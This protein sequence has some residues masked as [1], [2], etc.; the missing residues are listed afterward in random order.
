MSATCSPRVSELPYIQPLGSSGSRSYSGHSSTRAETGTSPTSTPSSRTRRCPVS[1][2][3]PIAAA[4]VCQRSQVATTS[5]SRDGSTTASIR[6]CDSETI[7]SKGSRSGS[8]S[9]TL[10]T[11]M[12]S[13]DA[14][15]RRHLAGRGGQP[16]RAEVLERDEQSALEQLQAALEQ[17]RF[18]EGVADLDAGALAVVPGLE[19]RRGEHRGAADPVASGGRAHDHQQVPGAGGGGADHRVGPGEPD[20]HRVHQAVVLVRTA[21][22]RPRR[23]P[24]ERRSSCRSGR[25]RRPRPRRGSGSARRRAR[26]S[27]ASRARRSAARRSRRRRGGSRRRRWRRPGTARRRSGGCATRP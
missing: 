4:P 14:A 16:G 3:S 9:G 1:V 17:L 8:R 26:R 6:S 5:S 24:W 23:R 13:P 7:T 19:L 27:A 20:A 15:L 12:S 21:R 25:S 18:L 2:I 22:S 11:S 10:A